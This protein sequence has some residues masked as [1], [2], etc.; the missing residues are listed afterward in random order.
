MQNELTQKILL[1]DDRKENLNA[2]SNLL[3]EFGAEIY[4]A[5]SGNKALELI[6]KHE[7]ALILLDVQMPNMD[8]FETARIMRSRIDTPI[9]FI[10]AFSR[11]KENIL[12]G[13]ESGAV[14]YLVKPIEPETLKGKVAIFLNLSR[15]KQ[16]L[17]KSNTQLQ[18]EITRREEIEKE[19][20]R[21]RDLLEDKVR[22]RTEELKLAYEELK[23]TENQI[24]LVIDNIPA[25]VAFV[26]KHL[27]YEFTNKQYQQFTGY[28]GEIQGKHLK[29]VL[30]Q[31]AYSRLHDNFNTV[32]GGKPV[33]FETEIAGVKQTLFVKADYLPH[34]V[35]GIPQGFFA[36]VQDIT[37]QKDEDE[38][39][40]Q[41]EA[42]LQQISKL[43][44]LA[45]LAGGVA[46]E[47]NNLLV[48]I[49]GFSKMVRKTLLEDSTEA[50]YL[51]RVINTAYRAKEIVNQ[52]RLFSQKREMKHKPLQ[53]E[54]TL[55]KALREMQDTIPEN[56]ML[57][58]SFED[59]NKFIMG[60]SQQFT[61][62]LQN[63]FDNAVEA[64]PAGGELKFNAYTCSNQYLQNLN[65][66]G[67][68]EPII[69]LEITDNGEGMSPETKE[70]M[71]VPFFTTKKDGKHTGL[72]MPVALGIVEQ[73]G[74]YVEVTS[75]P[76]EG[77]SV[78]IFLPILKMKHEN[79][80]LK[81]ASPD[82]ARKSILF[83]D[84]EESV[85]EM[86]RLS[87]ESAGYQVE[88]RNSGLEA[89]Q[90]LNEQPDNYDIVVMDQILTCMPGIELARK[91]KRI[92]PDLSI[93]LCTGF[94]SQEKEQSLIKMGADRVIQKPFDGDDLNRVIQD[95]ILESIQE[96]DQELIS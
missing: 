6:L 68:K 17:E 22:E 48:P 20:I 16:L 70:Q 55:K 10:T 45:T 92:R 28:Q 50:D 31:D 27:R 9:I 25:M 58:T 15:Q 41:I 88:T 54:G 5:T 53:L 7:F 21:A 33:T 36:L 85:L 51:D 23:A 72:G 44:A 90:V 3:D 69:C 34:L 64:M 65:K 80:I 14:D 57:K 56:I 38:R 46:H 93:I 47:F 91:M 26:D 62:L 29:E 84:N 73:L 67:D 94:I 79:Q 78:R 39:Q 52:V 49:I 74:G 66:N 96:L 1:V 61:H 13:Y 32:L 82:T 24:R 75:D 8:G 43:K 37:K 42:Q 89:L 81:I 63:I 40:R 12:K 83:V 71:F 77:T 19:L 35:D 95:V 60:N 87:L 59:G 4:T 18:Q 86:N 76:G 30:G 11:E 2:L